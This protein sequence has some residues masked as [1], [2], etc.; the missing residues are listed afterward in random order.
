[1]ELILDL[2]GKQVTEMVANKFCSHEEAFGLKNSR[3]ISNFQDVLYRSKA[4][5]NAFEKTAKAVPRV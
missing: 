4:Q 3:N 1:M 5:S 2:Q